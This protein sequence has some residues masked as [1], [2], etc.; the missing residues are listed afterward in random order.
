MHFIYT[1]DQIRIFHLSIPVTEYLEGPDASPPIY[2]YNYYI[3]KWN[4]NNN[5]SLNEN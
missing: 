1:F 2:I 4:N 3:I 5:E